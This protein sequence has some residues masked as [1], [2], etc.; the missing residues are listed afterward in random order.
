MAKNIEKE[1]A[2]LQGAINS[3]ATPEAQKVVMRNILAKLQS[4][5]KPTAKAKPTSVIKQVVKK[6]D[7]DNKAKQSAKIEVDWDFIEKYLPN[8]SSNDDVATS[9][10]LQRFIDGE[11]DGETE[12]ENI[13]PIFGEI[14][15]PQARVELK[16]ID[17][18]LMQNAIENYEETTGKKYKATSKAEPTKDTKKSNSLD[19]YNC[20]ELI[21]KEKAKA[22]KRVE[23]AVKKANAPK[24]TEA[25]KNKERIE[26][27][28]DVVETN[29]E[30]RLAKNE[31]SVE[32]IRKLIDKT[33]NFLKKLKEALSQAR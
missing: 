21:E 20:D 7:A 5:A 25:T 31:V 23:N 16:K 4:Q 3:P 22:K 19:D 1:I 14:T 2:D 11:M 9:D 13:W 6:A 12:E 10:D 8:Y 32:E 15:I 28:A 26:K 18:N 17:E 27:V 33:E 29:L 24:K 30:K